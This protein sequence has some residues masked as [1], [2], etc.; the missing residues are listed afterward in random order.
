MDHCKRKSVFIH[1]W[2]TTEK[3]CLLPH[4]KLLQ[5]YY[6][7]KYLFLLSVLAYD[8]TYAFGKTLS[9]LHA[10][11]SQ[12]QPI[13]LIPKYLN[14]LCPQHQQLKTSNIYPLFVDMAVSHV[15][16]LSP[17]VSSQ[18]FNPSV[19]FQPWRSSMTLAVGRINMEPFPKMY[20]Q[21]LGERSTTRHWQGSR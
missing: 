8:L 16:L 10:S 15:L 5:T 12:F 19:S 20:W 4:R 1:Q 9:S 6:K 13:C 17:S 3:L 11:G 2:L 7:C 14:L 18:L 21:S